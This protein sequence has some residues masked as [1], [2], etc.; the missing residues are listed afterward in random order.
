V[1][2]PSTHVDDQDNEKPGLMKELSDL[3]TSSTTSLVLA[4][5]RGKL[6]SDPDNDS[7]TCSNSGITFHRCG[8]D[9]QAPLVR[10]VHNARPTSLLTGAFVV[11]P[12]KMDSTSGPISV[13]NDEMLT[14]ML[15]SGPADRSHTHS[16]LFEYRDAATG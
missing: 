10:H 16:S 7:S 6:A 15:R 1:K 2:E 13:S 8:L 9:N 14:T 3:H 5:S 11:A 12:S 4:T